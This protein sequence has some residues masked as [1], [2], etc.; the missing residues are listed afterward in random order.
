M[1]RSTKFQAGSAAE[2]PATASLGV[3]LL[4]GLPTAAVQRGFEQARAF[5][6][7]HGLDTL[8]QLD[9]QNATRIGVLLPPFAEPSLI[10]ENWIDCDFLSNRFGRPA[11]IEGVSTF[12]DAD[13]AAEQL[14]SAVPLSQLGWGQSPFDGRTVAD[15]LVGQIE[16]ATH[17]VLVGAAPLPDAVARSLALLNP[18]A[19]RF[20]SHR[21]DFEPSASETHHAPVVPPWLEVLQ[22]ERVPTRGSDLFVYHRARPFDPIRFGNWL[23]DPPKELVRGKGNVWMATEPDLSFGY[24]CA[25]AVHRIFPAGRWWASRPEGTWP[26]CA[27]QRKRLLER[28]HPRFGDRRQELVFSGIDLDPD[29]LCAGLDA[30]L[31]AEDDVAVALAT[32]PGTDAEALANPVTRLQ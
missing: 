13:R 14:A 28:W 29:R 16:S 15:I 12:V 32:A 8:A 3:H 18:E 23:E 22:G 4:V 20:P 9:A 1:D 6:P 2:A 31:V 21:I 27:S 19:A 30:C 17:L 10:V 7:V 5:L 26:R 25:G 24:S 11:H